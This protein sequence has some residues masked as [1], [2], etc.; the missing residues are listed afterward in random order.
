MKTRPARSFERAVQTILS[1]IGEEDAAN[2]TERSVSLVRKWSDPDTPSL[3]SVKHALAL[4]RAYI[5]AGHGPGPISAVYQHRLEKIVAEMDLTNETLVGALFNLHA[6]VGSLTRSVADNLGEKPLEPMSL[7]PR[8]KET[9]LAE[10]ETLT[11]EASDL[12]AVVRKS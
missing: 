5:K 3:P 12:E 10:I 7:S 2:V 11:Q 9:L 6:A 4:D 1:A 8:M